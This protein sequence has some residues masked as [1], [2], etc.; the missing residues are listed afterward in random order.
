MTVEQVMSV[1]ALAIR[2]CGLRGELRS[3]ARKE[4]RMPLQTKERA[5]L[6]KPTMACHRPSKGA[7]SEVRGQCRLC[8]V[9][10]RI[11]VRVIERQPESSRYLHL[12]SQRRACSLRA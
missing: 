2:E 3:E 8:R 12:C 1:A 7:L 5:P 9:E 11:V 4:G 10:A 6:A